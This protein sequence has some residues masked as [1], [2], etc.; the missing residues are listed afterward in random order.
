MMSPNHVSENLTVYCHG[1]LVAAEAAR[2]NE[3]LT[4]CTACRA[5]LDTIKT[6]AALAAQWPSAQAPASL[7][8]AVER[9]LPQPKAKRFWQMNWSAPRLAFA[10]A[11][12][13]LLCV[14]GS[15]WL[16]QRLTRPWW[17]VTQIAGTPRVGAQAIQAGARGGKFTVGDWLQTDDAARALVRV[18]EIGF[19][20]VEPNT[21]MQLVT[22]QATEHRLALKRG[23]MHAYIWAPPKRFYV[24]T[25]S[26]TAVDLGCSYDL[27]VDDAGQSVLRV[28]T[29]WV[30]FEWH[31]VESFVPAGAICVTRPALGP[32][33]PYFEH[34]PASWQAALMRFDTDANARAAALD[35][36]LSQARQADALTLWHLLARAQG[37]ERG[38][39]FD[40]FAELIP[41]PAGVTRTG[42]L[43]GDQTMIDAWWDK[44]GLDSA[45]WWRIWKGPVPAALP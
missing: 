6:V 41:P 27:E 38:R 45:S 28:T 31:G 20:Q 18:G 5:E 37:D 36:V 42:V 19:V 2:V 3:H 13:S 39:V 12:L 26:A 23:K 15:L 44:L 25:P 1:E 17:E 7:W 30:A 24:N 43:S 10:G 4:Q 8:Q 35:E 32:G 40:R 16:Y 14:A 21:E 29:G 11:A 22:A 34:A 33:T 9:Q